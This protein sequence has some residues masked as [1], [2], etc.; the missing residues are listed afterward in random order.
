MPTKV[1]IL[2]SGSCCRWSSSPRTIL[3]DMP[4]KPT[5]DALHLLTLPCSVL[6]HVVNRIPHHHTGATHVFR[7]SPGSHAKRMRIGPAWPSVSAPIRA[8]PPL[9]GNGNSK[10]VRSEV[11]SRISKQTFCQLPS[12]PPTLSHLHLQPQ[13]HHNSTHILESSRSTPSP[14]KLL[15]PSFALI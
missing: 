14:P 8:S 15:I 5:Y 13:I 2:S 7:S 1:M 11:H 10:L 4:P 12:H 9:K 6:Q 3:Y